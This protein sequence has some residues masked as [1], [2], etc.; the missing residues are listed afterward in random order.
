MMS[1]VE[2]T[3]IAVIATTPTSD[4]PVNAHV[5]APWPKLE[6]Q[7]I[8]VKRDWDTEPNTETSKPE[9]TQRPISKYWDE[10]DTLFYN[11]WQGVVMRPT[12]LED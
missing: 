3:P 6:T 2:T 4:F 9:C 12:R 5:R 8:K 10:Y 11:A 1:S 7:M